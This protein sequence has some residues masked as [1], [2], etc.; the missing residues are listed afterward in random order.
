[1]NKTNKGIYKLLVFVLI[2]VAFMS[3]ACDDGKVEKTRQDGG[4][5]I[6]TTMVGGNPVNDLYWK[7]VCFG[8][9]RESELGRK[10]SYYCDLK[11]YTMQAGSGE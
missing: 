11:G 3:F 6:A 7:T 5:A 1:M 4:Q 10:I 8:A 2:L 9:Y